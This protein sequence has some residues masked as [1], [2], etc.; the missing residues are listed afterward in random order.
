MWPCLMNACEGAGGAGAGGAIGV[1]EVDVDLEL[2][3]VKALRSA[4]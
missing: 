1:D 2:D 3:E 4:N